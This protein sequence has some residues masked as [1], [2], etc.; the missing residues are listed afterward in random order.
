MLRGKS[1]YEKNVG[2]IRKQKILEELINLMSSN[3]VI[4]IVDLRGVRASQLQEIRHMLRNNNINVK[5][6]KN[7]LFIK[8]LEKCKGYVKNS[9]D[10]I[11]YLKGQNAFIFAKENPFSILLLLEKNKVYT[12]AKA[13]DIAPNDIVVPAGNT[14]MSPGPI[15]SKFNTFKIPIKIEEG[16]IW[17]TKDTVVAK[18]GDVI[19]QD[20]ADL[21]KRLN[22]KPIEVKLNV[23]A[24]YFDG[25]VLSGDQ[26]VVDINRYRQSIIDAVKIAHVLSI[27]AVIPIRETIIQI[28]SRAVKIADVISSRTVIPDPNLIKRSLVNA[29]LKAMVVAQKIMD[30]NPEIKIEGIITPLKT[31]SPPTE[32][33][34]KVVEED[35]KKEEKEE[36]EIAEGLAALFG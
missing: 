5:V 15:I 10:I 12:E 33:K 9:E 7:S 20:L 35:K 11:K 4:T 3:N 34:G 26:L 8:A 18:K 13:K 36:E 27:E 1:M 28:I 17:I 23:K 6:S 22:I 25:I 32:G 2:K 24:M 30:I 31:V 16:S 29:K 19:S 21:L 14:G